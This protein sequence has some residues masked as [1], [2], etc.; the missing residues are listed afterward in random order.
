MTLIV[1]SIP[2]LKLFFGF[3]LYALSQMDAQKVVEILKLEPHRE[4]GYFR[5]TYAAKIN[6]SITTD[7]EMTGEASE[8][9]P[10][11]GIE[12][13]IMTSIYYLLTSESSIMRM[14][15]NRSDI[16]HYYHLGCPVE[17]LIIQPNGEFSR[18]RLGPNI[19]SGEKL[20]VFI[21]GGCWRCGQMLKNSEL[22][23]NS[24]DFALTSEAVAPGF[25][26]T[27][28]QLATREQIK[29]KFPHL[30]ETLQ[31]YIAK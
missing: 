5:R 26:Y 6:V 15:I 17:Y 14:N 29:S 31:S 16:I 21:P 11:S 28:N 27:D 20:Q 25:D 7:P 8:N 1:R 30:W 22:T 10:T 13:P 2:D 9:D 12:R 3:R 23:V 24:A 18:E 4:G 19:L